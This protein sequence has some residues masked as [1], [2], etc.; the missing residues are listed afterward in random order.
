LEKEANIS[1]KKLT[2]PYVFSSEKSLTD[3]AKNYDIGLETLTD[4]IE[5]LA[6]P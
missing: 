4:I 2:L 5:E 6:N 3:I 1:K